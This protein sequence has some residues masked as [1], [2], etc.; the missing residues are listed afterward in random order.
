MPPVNI[1]F[2]KILR[3][4]AEHGVEFIVVG[5]VS[6]V[7]HGAIVNTA[8]VDVVHR[9]TPDNLER[10]L[11]A[12]DAMDAYYR[13]QASRRLK[14]NASHLASPGHQLLTTSD[15]HLDVLGTIGESLSY[16][17]LLEST[18][19]LPIGDGFRVRVLN[20]DR[21]ILVKQEAGRD[22][23]LV[24]LP[25]LRRLLEEK[26]RLAAKASQTTPSPSRPT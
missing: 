4:L 26:R 24:V 9:R 23:D 22:K 11:K 12:L 13:L 5:G 20:L 2:L 16:E 8:D 25:I 14:P 10:L 18:E 19:E 17:D 21:L 7:L 6:A 1:N 3:T 15:G